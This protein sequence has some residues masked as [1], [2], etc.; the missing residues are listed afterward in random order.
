M[1]EQTLTKVA[2]A[3]LVAGGLNW[4]LVGLL[5]VDLVSLFFGVDTLISTALYLVT[6]AAAVYYTVVK[7]RVPLMQRYGH[8]MR[9][10]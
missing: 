7:V 6:G 8:F 2:S 10:A 3:I 5:Q 4:G 1:K 9:T